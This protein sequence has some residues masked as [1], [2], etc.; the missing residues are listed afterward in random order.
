MNSVS[1]S[2]CISVMLFYT[3]T[4]LCLITVVDDIGWWEI[5]PGGEYS[6]EN[7][8]G[9]CGEL[10]ESLTLYQAEMCNFLYPISDPTQKSTPYFRPESPGSSA[11]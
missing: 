5:C 10:P 6:Q 3:L 8:V 9:V 11:R 4:V 7:W 1:H 2:V